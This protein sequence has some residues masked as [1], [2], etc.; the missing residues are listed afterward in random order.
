MTIKFKTL[1]LAVFQDI[2]NT[3]QLFH[4]LKLE[5]FGDMR[6]ACYMTGEKFTILFTKYYLGFCL[7][8]MTGEKASL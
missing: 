4:L 6:W 8:Y 7:K 5:V 1:P 3:Y 2:N